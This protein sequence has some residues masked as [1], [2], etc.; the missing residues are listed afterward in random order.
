M[1]T[2]SKRLVTF[3]QLRPVFGITDSRTTI[4]RKMKAVPRQFPQCV[5]SGSRI[6]WLEDEIDE[7]VASLPRGNADDYRAIKKAKD[8]GNQPS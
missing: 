8:G 4:R 5:S 2:K 6:A 7:Y 1:S 3:E